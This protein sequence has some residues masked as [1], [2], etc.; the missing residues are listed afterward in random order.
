M[1]IPFSDWVC[2]DFPKGMGMRCDVEDHVY[3]QPSKED[4][5]EEVGRGGTGIT[6]V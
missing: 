3:V 2:G 1:I 4:R 5:W 6:I